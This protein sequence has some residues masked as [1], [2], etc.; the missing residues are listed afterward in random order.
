MDKAEVWVLA[1]LLYG[2]IALLLS[3]NELLYV[4]LA[5]GTHILSSTDP[6]VHASKSSAD[7]FVHARE[8]T[9]LGQ[10]WVETQ[11]FL[12]KNTSSDSFGYREIE[13]EL[14]CEE[15]EDHPRQLEEKA[16]GAGVTSDG[17]IEV[18]SAPYAYDQGAEAKRDD[19]NGA[20]L[21]WFCHP[22]IWGVASSGSTVYKILHLFGE[23]VETIDPAR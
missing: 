7:P 19:P 11:Y 3:H 20:P 8:H 1:R 17:Y 9:G 21:L 6:V 14:R 15:S 13:Q 5:L 16:T 2:V 18:Q 4:I 23:S 12:Q 22:Y 10:T